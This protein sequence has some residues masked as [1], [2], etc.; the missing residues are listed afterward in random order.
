MNNQSS[1]QKLIYFLMVSESFALLELVVV[2][3]TFASVRWKEAENLTSEL[4]LLTHTLN[5]T[6]GWLNLV[7]FWLGSFL[8]FLFSLILFEFFFKTKNEVYPF[9][10]IGLLLIFSFF[11]YFISSAQ[12]INGRFTKVISF[13][14]IS[15]FLFFLWLA[16]SVLAR[17]KAKENFLLLFTCAVFV[18]CNLARG[19]LVLY[20]IKLSTFQI[21]L[22]SLFVF[23]FLAISAFLGYIFDSLSSRFF[24]WSKR[25]VSVA[26]FLFGISI[27]I[28]PLV[29]WKDYYFY[30][31]ANSETAQ[32]P[33]LIMIVLDTVRADHLSLYG[34]KLK[35]S[36]FL[37]SLGSKSLVFEKAYSTSPWTLPSHA[38]FFT[39]L[40]PSEHNCTYENM[41]LA[42]DF[43]TISENLQKKGYF[44]VGISNNAL[45]NIASGIP[46][47]F[48]I[49]I[50]N[51]QLKIYTGEIIKG[52]LLKFFPKF[53]SDNGARLTNRTIF[54]W[55]S[56]FSSKRKPFFIFINYMEAHVPYPRDISAY[57]FFKNPKQAQ[58]KYPPIEW[59]FYNC[60]GE[61]RKE[62][63]ETVVK[64]YD[65]S[66][67]YLDSQL[68]RLYEQITKLG[69]DENTIIVI[70]SD[71]GE[72]FY[73]H[74][75]WGHGIHLYETELRVPL[76]I[77]Y[78][79]VFTPKRT[80][81]LFSLKELP[82]FLLDLIQG[83]SEK[84]L[85]D[86]L[87][88]SKTVFAEVFKPVMYIE[89]I[90]EFCQGFDTSEL[91][92]RQKAIIQFPYKLIRD[93]RGNEELYDVSSDF[94]E[95]NNLINIKP[96]VYAQLSEKMDL[97][98]RSHPS[99][100]FLKKRMDSVTFKALKALGYIK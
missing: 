67:S 86:K 65:G 2:P 30:S 79:K 73:E 29:S 64:W 1:V 93:S 19:L 49:F 97:Y 47:G 38:S 90:P 35:T 100:L 23:L 22:L 91:D 68:Q 61:H 24:S 42:K 70:L 20:D 36:P 7:C 16:I 6:T 81:N 57:K 84:E 82:D 44:T 98:L 18:L 50:E 88:N 53:L 80:E 14:L 52:F 95:R 94:E 5:S 83:K 71:H 8:I 89:R 54:K 4:L 33:N 60:Y 56:K 76:L 99:V 45:L 40:M 13:Y 21:V 55:L 63:R 96:E 27:V 78:P 43:T 34:Y 41:K 72:S 25:G 87:E 31:S 66:I 9:I 12:F 75:W 77:Y 15:G 69:L 17:K 32:A 62:F 51:N 26:F 48:H 58:E 3:L 37:E 74:K 46:Q 92:K 85:L 39:G 10:W 28:S 59:D 11:S